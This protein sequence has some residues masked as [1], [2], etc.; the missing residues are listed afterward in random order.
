MIDNIHLLELDGNELEL[1]YMRAKLPMIKDKIRYTVVAAD[2]VTV[3]ILA[4]Q[5]PTAIATPATTI[6]DVAIDLFTPFVKERRLIVNAMPYNKEPTLTPG[7]QIDYSSTKELLST[8][9]LFLTSDKMPDKA[10]ISREAFD[11]E[12]GIMIDIVRCGTVQGSNESGNSCN[13]GG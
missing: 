3:H 4:V 11:H 8:L 2:P 13:D 10:M 12:V 7:P 1:L 6:H 9:W 5:A